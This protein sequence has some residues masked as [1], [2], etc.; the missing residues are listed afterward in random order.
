MDNLSIMIRTIRKANINILHNSRVTGLLQLLSME[1]SNNNMASKATVQLLQ[2]HS[3]GTINT[4]NIHHKASSTV[5]H[6]LEVS[7][8]ASSLR[9]KTHTNSNTLA[10]NSNKTCAATTTALQLQQ[11]STHNPGHTTKRPMIQTTRM[12]PAPPAVLKTVTA[13]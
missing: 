2:L 1:N 5:H 10:I 12:V 7:N 8:T 9:T 3:M 4:T 6:R 13:V 11:I